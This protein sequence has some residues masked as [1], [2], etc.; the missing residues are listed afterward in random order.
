MINQH[1]EKMGLAHRGA[2]HV[3]AEAIHK[4][5]ANAPLLEDFTLA[6][7]TALGAYMPVYEAPAGTSIITEGETGD[8]M[9]LLITG[10]VD[11]MRLDRQ[12]R[13]SRIA[14]VNEGHALGEMSM[15]D[16]EPRFASCISLEQTCFAVLT[17]ETLALLVH[18]RPELGAKILV[19]LVQMLAQRL[20][21]TTTKLVMAM[22]NEQVR[23]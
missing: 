4:L 19:K 21:N 14:V 23:L 12:G 20:R 9:I 22:E 6:E 7:I 8:F 15:I 10:S 5:V 17:R 11:V 1:F 18:R 13:P 2:A 3:F 16:G